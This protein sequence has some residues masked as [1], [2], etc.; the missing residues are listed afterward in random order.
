M[1]L[2]YIY[3]ITFFYKNQI[4]FNFYGS[5]SVIR[6][7]ISG[8]KICGCR[9]M[10]RTYKLQGQSLVALPIRLLGNIFF[11]HKILKESKNIFLPPVSYLLDESRILF[12]IIFIS[13]NIFF[14][15]KS[16]IFTIY[17]FYFYHILIFIYY[18]LYIIF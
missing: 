9:G 3:F 17:I 11:Q 10:I 7:P 1:C 18:F 16:I 6:I 8:I 5:R 13:Y 4:F 12:C 2:F 15:I 14:F